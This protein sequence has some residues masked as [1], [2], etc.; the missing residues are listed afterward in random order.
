M[1][2]DLS[3]VLLLKQ[4]SRELVFHSGFQINPFIRWVQLVCQMTSDAAPELNVHPLMMPCRYDFSAACK[5]Y[6]DQL[7]YP[8]EVDAVCRVVLYIINRNYAWANFR[9]VCGVVKILEYHLDW[10]IQRDT[11]LDD[12]HGIHSFLFRVM[13]H[14]RA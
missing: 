1:P 5:L 6:P 12:W 9:E 14:N 3:L 8:R 10:R 7:E 11:P 13:D 4:R 2:D